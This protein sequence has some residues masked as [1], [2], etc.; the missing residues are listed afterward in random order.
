[1]AKTPS[2]AQQASED[3]E[4]DAGPT[5]QPANMASPAQQPSASSNLDAGPSHQ[6]PKAHLSPLELL[7]QRLARVQE[8]QAARLAAL[9]KPRV[10]RPLDD[11]Q[12]LGADLNELPLRRTL[13]L[14]QKP[15]KRKDTLERRHLSAPKSLGEQLGHHIPKDE[16]FGMR[17]EIPFIMVTD[18]FQNVVDIWLPFT[19]IRS[20]TGMDL[21]P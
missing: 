8:E 6:S 20:S 18:V 19:S 1:M 3:M 4:C 17:P 10:A 14:T 5:D 16:V 21:D 11:N 13:S 9:V 12:L 2:P 7:R 15:P